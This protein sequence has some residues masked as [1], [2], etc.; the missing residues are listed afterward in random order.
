[1]RR[2]VLLIIAS[3]PA[4]AA[5]DD[6][7]GFV[8]ADQIE[9][10][11]KDDKSAWDIQGWYGDDYHKFWWK[12]EGE[13]EQGDIESA[14]LQ[15]LYSR[16]V[17]AFY[18]LQ[19]GLKYEDLETTDQ[20]S[21]VAGMQG[22][23]PYRIDYDL[24]VAVSEGGDVILD[25]ELERDFLVTQRWIVQPKLKAK[26][27]LNDSTDRAIDAGINKIEAGVRLRYEVTRKFAPYVG[28]KWKRDFDDGKNDTSALIGLTF[29]LP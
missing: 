1:M 29:W 27:A 19:F 25:A 21:L 13:L 3:T 12:S 28:V 2:F 7:Y 22:D 8:M 10:L 20:V 15:L 11:S 26:A 17:G 23:A 5:D 6:L 9:H 24:S 4:F 16:A 14:D 18:D